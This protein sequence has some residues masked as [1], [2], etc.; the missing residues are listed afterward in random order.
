MRKS[1]KSSVRKVAS[2][3]A[4]LDRN[5]TIWSIWGPLE[6]LEFWTEHKIYGKLQLARW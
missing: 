1:E 5:Q 3:K 2:A 6:N 4:N